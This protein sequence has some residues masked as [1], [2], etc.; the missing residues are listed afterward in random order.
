MINFKAM[1]FLKGTTGTNLFGALFNFTFYFIMDHKEQL[2]YDPLN[3]K[4][5]LGPNSDGYSIWNSTIWGSEGLLGIEFTTTNGEYFIRNYSQYYGKNWWNWNGITYTNYLKV[6]GRRTFFQ[7]GDEYRI[8][9]WLPQW[10]KINYP[11]H[12]DRWRYPELYNPY[13]WVGSITGRG[14]GWTRMITSLNG[15]PG[16][17]IN[18]GPHDPQSNRALYRLSYRFIGRQISNII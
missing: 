15:I 18:F 5:W 13:N 16:I 11:N 17:Y 10:M 9:D 12:V 2:V 7:P 14:G 4:L 6:R 3:G 8:N 1:P